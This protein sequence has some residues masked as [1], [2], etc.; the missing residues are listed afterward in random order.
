MGFEGTSPVVQQGVTDPLITMMPFDYITGNLAANV[1][2][3][4]GAVR[5]EGS[6]VFGGL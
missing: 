4:M 1:P 5:D 2:L 3:M 6:Y